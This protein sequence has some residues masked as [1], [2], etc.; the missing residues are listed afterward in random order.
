MH[1]DHIE[2]ELKKEINR[3]EK[4][5]DRTQTLRSAAWIGSGLAAGLVLSTMASQIPLLAGM[6]AGGALLNVALKGFVS[7]KR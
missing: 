7:R 5:L 4:K 3:I 1:T 6:V 2:K